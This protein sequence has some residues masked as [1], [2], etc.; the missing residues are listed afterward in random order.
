MTVGQRHGE[1]ACLHSTTSNHE[2]WSAHLAAGLK[3]S[4]P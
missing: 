4:S 1:D 3:P 2:N